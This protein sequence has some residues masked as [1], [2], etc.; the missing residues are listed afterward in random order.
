[1]SGQV[2]REKIVDCAH[3]GAITLTLCAEQSKA[4]LIR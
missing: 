1:M 2:Q 4:L 3:V